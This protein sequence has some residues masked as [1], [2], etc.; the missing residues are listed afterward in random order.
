MSTLKLSDLMEKLYAGDYLTDDEFELYLQL[1]DRLRVY[2]KH[3]SNR[4][5]TKNYVRERM[6]Q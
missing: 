1:L 4:L 3:E 6:G 5:S 2:E